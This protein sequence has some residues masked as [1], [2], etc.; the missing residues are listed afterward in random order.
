[1]PGGCVHEQEHHAGAD[2]RGRDSGEPAL[3]RDPAAVRPMMPGSLRESGARPGRTRGTLDALEPVRTR[4]VF[5]G[6]DLTGRHPIGVTAVAAARYRPRLV[7]LICIIPPRREGARAA[8]TVAGHTGLP[9]GTGAMNAGGMIPASDANAPL[10]DALPPSV[11]PFAA[12]L[13][14]VLATALATAFAITAAA[15]AAGSV[16]GAADTTGAI[17]S[18]PAAGAQLDAATIR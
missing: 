5:V 16:A 4:A 15:S 6:A 7:S 14:A 17:A 12:S 18:G 2:Q 13:A 3:P 10:S 8:S 11:R 1:M 9:A